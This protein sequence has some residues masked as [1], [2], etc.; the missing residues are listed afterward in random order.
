MSSGTLWV[1]GPTAARPFLW[2]DLNRHSHMHAKV[3]GNGMKCPTCGADNPEQVEFC[4]KCSSR[5]PNTKPDR[6]TQGR[7]KTIRLPTALVVLAVIAVIL[8]P[9]LTYVYFSPDYSWSDSIQDADGDGF[10]DSEDLFPED[11]TEWSDIDADGVG[12]I[13]D[14]WDYG[15]AAIRISVDIYIGDGTAD[16]GTDGDGTPGDPY[17]VIWVDTDVS[18]GDY[19]MEE[20]CYDVSAQ[21]ETFADTE[22]IIEAFSVTVDIDEAQGELRWVIWVYDDDSDSYDMFDCNGDSGDIG[23]LLTFAHPFTSSIVTDGSEDG[24]D[25]ADCMLALSMTLGSEELL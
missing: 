14:I 6:A 25:G 10:S 4:L 2:E 7:R 15:N 13:A 24:N 5:I 1:Q 16:L 9:A 12:D 19:W 21:S 20:G 17:F 3:E 23:L 18:S 11:G 22:K 8:G